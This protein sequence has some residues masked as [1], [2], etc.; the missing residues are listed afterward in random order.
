MIVTKRDSP[1][2]DLHTGGVKVKQNLTNAM[3]ESDTEI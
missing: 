1:K 2:C 3:T